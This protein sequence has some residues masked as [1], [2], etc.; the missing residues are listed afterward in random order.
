MSLEESWPDF[1]RFMI[2]VAR[3]VSTIRSPTDGQ[4]GLAVFWTTAAARKVA[5]RTLG[6][7]VIEATPESFVEAIREAHERGVPWLY[8]GSEQNDRVFFEKVRL[9]IALGQYARDGQHRHG[10]QRPDSDH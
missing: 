2:A 7:V 10:G 1:P 3:I 8:I 6:A 5:R 4:D 9:T